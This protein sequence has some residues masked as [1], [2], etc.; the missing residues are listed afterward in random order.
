VAY[1]SLVVSHDSPAEVGLL[2][3]THSFAEAESLCR[4]VDQFAGLASHHKQDSVVFHHYSEVPHSAELHHN[5]DCPSR[6]IDGSAAARSDR[7]AGGGCWVGR[8]TV[9]SG[10]VVVVESLSRMD[11]EEQRPK[12]FDQ[13]L[14]RQDGEVERT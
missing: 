13:L 1:Y 8:V 14:V 3:H 10:A 6:R 2:F 12:D 5:A 11:L 9:V 4:I 7:P